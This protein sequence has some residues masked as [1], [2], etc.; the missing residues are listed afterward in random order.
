MCFLTLNIWPG[1]QPKAAT[2]SPKVEAAMT[3]GRSRAPTGRQCARS[4]WLPDQSCTTGSRWLAVNEC[5]RIIRSHP[6]Y[7][8]RRRPTANAS[9][10]YGQLAW[11][12]CLKVCAPAYVRPL[13]SRSLPRIPATGGANLFPATREG[14]G[15][16]FSNALHENSELIA[17]PLFAH[18]APGAPCRFNSVRTAEICC[19]SHMR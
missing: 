14:G 11:L 5:Q 10:R 17:R 15:D 12:K 7:F 6:R 16:L 9:M 19:L 4:S 1:T 13:Y 2:S 8:P 3:A 18:L